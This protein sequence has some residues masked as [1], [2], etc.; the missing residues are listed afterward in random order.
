MCQFCKTFF[1]TVRIAKKLECFFRLVC[2][3]VRLE[4]TLMKHF[5]RLLCKGR[6]LAFPQ[7]FS[8]YF[9]L[10]I[11]LSVTKKKKFYSIDT[12]KKGM[13]HSSNSY[14]KVCFD[15]IK[16]FL[17]YFCVIYRLEQ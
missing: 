3:K 15:Q 10:L 16:R 17:N 13:L 2:L 9:T 8:Y 6:F 12:D 7:A 1:S 14:E 11:Q 4:P 5:T